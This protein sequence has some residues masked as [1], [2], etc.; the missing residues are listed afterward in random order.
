[1]KLGASNAFVIRWTE[2]TRTLGEK[3]GWFGRQV[4]VRRV[5]GNVWGEQQAAVC[6]RHGGLNLFSSFVSRVFEARGCECLRLAYK[7]AFRGWDVS[8]IRSNSLSQSAVSN[9][10]VGNT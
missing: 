1:M 5:L 10:K 6:N 9:G 3:R 4:D 2:R 8:E 7:P